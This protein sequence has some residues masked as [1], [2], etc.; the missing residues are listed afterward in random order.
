M[1]METFLVQNQVFTIEEARNALEIEKNRSTLNNLLAY[2]LQ[3]G[4]IIRI[5]KGLYYT[6][7]RGAD[8]KT[9]PTD[10]YLIAGKIAPDSILA[11]H[12]S[13]GFHGKLHSL[14][15]H[16]IYITQ[17]KVKPP[18]VFRDTTFKGIAIPKESL[19]NPDLGVEIVDY[20]GCKIRV[21]TLERTFVDVL[22]RPAL[23]NNWEEIWR[24]LE[25]IEYL[26]LQQVL[27]YAKILNNVTTYARI[28]FFLDQHREMLGL[29][30]K[31]LLPFDAFKPKSPHYL[32]RHNKEPNQLIARWNLIVPK[33]LLQKTWEEPHEN[34]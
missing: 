15:T 3:K 22:D 12:T 20:Q 9:Y 33:S 34:F 8:A 17:R 25:S 23:I 24:S 26:N 10:P 28:A 5:R 27:A 32:D 6:I 13:L 19:A 30:E 21:T 31:D 11:Y 18:F 1:D 7:A 2:H 14:R 4:H 29:T 16:F